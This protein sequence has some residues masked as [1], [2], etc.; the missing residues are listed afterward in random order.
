MSPGRTVWYLTGMGAA[1]Q[2]ECSQ[3]GTEPRPG[4][5]QR[6]E[7]SLTTTSLARKLGRA[8]PVIIMSH[9]LFQVKKPESCSGHQGSQCQANFLSDLQPWPRKS[10]RHSAANADRTPP[11]V[12]AGGCRPSLPRTSTSV[13]N[14]HPVPG[15]W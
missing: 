5:G 1:G 14:A 4:L 3:E 11:E 8:Q 12:S 9:P 13:G 2:R 15:C 10:T 7:G 6:P